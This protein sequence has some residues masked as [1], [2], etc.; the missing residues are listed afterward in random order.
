MSFGPP[1]RPPSVEHRLLATAKQLEV[2]RA[3]AEAD[4]RGPDGERRPGAV[5]RLLRRMRSALGSRH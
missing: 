2:D 4:R 1:G 3:I 5:A